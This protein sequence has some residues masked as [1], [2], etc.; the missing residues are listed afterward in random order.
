VRIELTKRF[1]AAVRRLGADDAAAVDAALAS[2]L[3][4]FGRP[5]AHGGK[6]VRVLRPPLFELRATRDLRLL[7]VREADV[8]RVDFVGD[9][10]AV[11]DYLR[12]TH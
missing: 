7:F 2:L 4:T 1:L 11:T 12:N 8:L 3:A 10:G 6:S 9:H 5:H